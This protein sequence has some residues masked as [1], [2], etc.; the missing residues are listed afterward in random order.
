MIIKAHVFYIF[1]PIQLYFLKN[2]WNEDQNLRLKIFCIARHEAAI[3]QYYN[4]SESLGLEKIV[5]CN[6]SNV[7]GI[8]NLVASL[9]INF[10]ARRLTVGNY[11]SK[12][13]KCASK[14]RGIFSVGVDILDEGSNIYLFNKRLAKIDKES[15]VYCFSKFACYNNPLFKHVS[16]LL[17]D[18]QPRATVVVSD[19]LDCHFLIIGSAD[20]AEG[21]VTF[22]TYV[23]KIRKLTAIGICAYYPHRRENVDIIRGLKNL[24]VIDAEYPFEHWF[25]WIYLNNRKLLE[26]LKLVSF[27]ST[28]MIICSSIHPG[29]RWLIFKYSHSEIIESYFEDYSIIINGLLNDVKLNKGVIDVVE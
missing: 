5:I 29:S 26:G 24:R 22:G 6:I 18:A 13:Y 12:I 4:V 17:A 2:I 8:L 16:P 11:N 10:Y 20:V 15:N 3:K 25:L 27:G 7:F 14:V 19:I 28:C 9:L 21:L 1:S 23:E